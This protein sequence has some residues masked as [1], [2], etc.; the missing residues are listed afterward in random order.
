MDERFIARRNRE[1]KSRERELIEIALGLAKSEGLHKVSP[2]EVAKHS[3][4]SRA[5]VYKLWSSREDLLAACAIRSID[6]QISMYKKIL[7]QWDD[8]AASL[9]VFSLGYIWHIRNN[10]TLFQLS[11]IGRSAE[12]LASCAEETRQ[13]RLAAEKEL[14]ELI[15][16]VDMDSGERIYVGDIAILDAVNTVRAMT[17]GFGIFSTNNGKSAWGD[18][19]T[20]IHAATLIIKVMSGLGWKVNHLSLDS[21][22]SQLKKQLEAV[23]D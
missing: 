23:D 13:R 1:I 5:T 12:N 17:T 4:Y 7:P 15:M 22:C 16:S 18:E 19:L 21:I 11:L 3:D 9:L 8:H 20:D 2:G 14:A 6:M 10:S